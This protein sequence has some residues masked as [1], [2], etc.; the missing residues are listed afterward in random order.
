[1]SYELRRFLLPADLEEE[2]VAELWSLGALGFETHEAEAG[3]LVLD[4][5]FPAPGS[6]GAGHLALAHWRRR[7]VLEIASQSL[8]DRDWLAPYRAAAEPFDVGR[9]LR[10][11]PREPSAETA[12]A[13]TRSVLKIPARAAFRPVRDLGPQVTM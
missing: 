9:R 1:M 11:D 10:I 8:E 6:A 12:A 3:R 5:Y 7:G 13:G 2:L 4:A